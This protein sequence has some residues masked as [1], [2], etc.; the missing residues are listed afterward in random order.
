MS[1]FI[2]SAFTSPLHLYLVYILLTS[3]TTH[4]YNLN[5]ALHL[6]CDFL[7][8]CLYYTNRIKTVACC[9]PSPLQTNMDVPQTF[10]DMLAAVDREI[11]RFLELRNKIIALQ[12]HKLEIETMRERAEMF[13]DMLFKAST[14]N[15]EI[16]A[17]NY[18]KTFILPWK[19]Y[20]LQSY[21]PK[22]F[23]ALPEA[24]PVTWN[25]IETSI[26]LLQ[27]SETLK[28]DSHALPILE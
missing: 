8:L 5:W 16:Q 3:C 22:T 4:R 10:E 26:L 21:F 24:I 18:V 12:A 20:L 6:F 28:E 2:C 1:L 15:N 27:L 19:N 11:I 14:F 23:N 7:F 13:S 17:L 9:D 25:H